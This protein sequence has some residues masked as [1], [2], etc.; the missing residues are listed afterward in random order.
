[1][2]LNVVSTAPRTFFIVAFDMPLLGGSHSAYHSFARPAG[3]RGAPSLQRERLGALLSRL[4]TLLKWLQSCQ[5]SYL[6]R[7][8][9]TPGEGRAC[10]SSMN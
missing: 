3:N 1:M 10:F 9:L 2:N 8:G 4:Y 5:G 7:H 6:S